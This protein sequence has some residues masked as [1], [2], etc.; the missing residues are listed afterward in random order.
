MS[1]RPASAAGS[2]EYK[3]QTYYFCST[4]CL[5]KFRE[6]PELFL[7]KPAEPMSQPV[8]I[9]RAIPDARAGAKSSGSD[10]NTY[11]CPMHP[12][13]RQN[14]PGS[15]PKCGMALER[16]APQIEGKPKLITVAPASGFNE[17]ELVGWP[18][19]LNVAANILWRPQL[20]PAPRRAESS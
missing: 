11:T 8:G 4:Q 1:V 6:N 2:F 16:V 12:E 17:E 20:L 3:D 7:N 15:C 18:P 9:S 5:E 13:V 14:K 19:V 10:Q